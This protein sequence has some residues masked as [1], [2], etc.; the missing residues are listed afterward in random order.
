[1]RQKEVAARFE[2]CS[3]DWECIHR[4]REIANFANFVPNWLAYNYKNLI[5]DH[6]IV[7]PLNDDDYVFSFI[8]TYVQKGSLFLESFNRF[9]TLSIESG[10]ADK[11]LR[12]SVFVPLAIRNAADVSDGYFAFTLSHIRG[13]FYILF[14]GHKLSIL[15]FLSEVLYKFRFRQF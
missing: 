7:C 8:S 13:A 14:L 3:A 10:M 11:A 5:N 1:L 4:N 6:S 12:D 2:I 15:L 9:I